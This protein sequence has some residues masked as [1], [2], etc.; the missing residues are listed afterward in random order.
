M[1]TP[2]EKS[3]LPGK[4]I[5][6]RGGS[7]PR[8]CI[9]Q[10]SQPNTLPS[11]RTESATHYKRVFFRPLSKRTIKYSIRMKKVK[12]NENRSRTPF[13]HSFIASLALW[14]RRPPGDRKISNNGRKRDSNPGS[15][16]LEADTLTTRPTKVV[17]WELTRLTCDVSPWRPL[18][19][20]IKENTT[21]YRRIE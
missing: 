17:C 2:R 5:L 4:K 11:S 9:K 18:L 16:A 20:E 1:L 6:L 12:L 21:K 8:R 14:L 7:N 15:S 3:S 10:D 13:P 19:V